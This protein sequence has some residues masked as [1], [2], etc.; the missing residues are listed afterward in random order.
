MTSVF[1][2]FRHVNSLLTPGLFALLLSF[3]P[4]VVVFVSGGISFLCMTVL[5]RFLHPRL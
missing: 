3:F 2:T 1:M 5:S 4:L